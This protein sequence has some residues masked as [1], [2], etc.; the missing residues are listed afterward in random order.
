MAN[1]QIRPEQAKTLATFDD[2]QAAGSALET[3]GYSLEE[4]LHG[5]ISQINRLKHTSTAGNDWFDDLIAPSTFENGAKRGIDLVN[6]D[7]HDFERKRLLCV[8]HNLESIDVPLGQNYVIL[9]A[10]ARLPMNLT[11]AVGAVT[12]LG[13]VVAA[14]T[15]TFGTHSLDVVTG[16]N[17]LNP[18]NI[19]P[20]VDST[21]RDPILSSNRQVY[22]LLQSENA[23]DGHTI[24]A[25]TPNRLQISFVRLDSVGG[26]LEAVPVSDI[27]QVDFTYAA[28]E[29]IG[30]EDFDEQVLLPGAL[31]DTTA[32]GSGGGGTLEERAVATT[33]GLISANT[34]VIGSGGGANLTNV[35]LDYSGVDFA[36]QVK[37]YLNGRLMRNGVNPGS[38]FDV[39]PSAI[40]AEQEAG[41]FY[42]E[43]DIQ[44]GDTIQMFT[45][46]ATPGSGTAAWGGI[47]GTLSD[48]T[49]LQTALD[50][51]VDGPHKHYTFIRGKVG[52]STNGRYYRAN[53][54]GPD[55]YLAYAVNGGAVQGS[56]NA[57]N[58]GTYFHIVPFDG[59][60]TRIVGVLHSPVL[61]ED[62][63]L[64]LWRHAVTDDSTPVLTE[65]GT[66][67]GF[68]ACNGA[69]VTNAANQYKIDVPVSTNNTVARGDAL[70][71]LFYATTAV[72]NSAIVSLMVEISET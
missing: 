50:A 10:A 17:A 8:K 36:T 19:V 24:L 66:A 58:L 40:T 27:E 45:G 34:L 41:A 18:K 60:V 2:Q 47:T 6:Q 32:G 57:P 16:F 62:V 33:T 46:D 44:S 56:P 22:G 71:L 37:I 21:T 25:N 15:G 42:C 72:S 11:A 51:K 1:T 48:Q 35:L 52:G 26:T 67:G 31:F 39:Y 55:I 63:D 68:F 28:V 14:H 23:T 49:D 12:T 7:L 65:I 69:T 54:L 43:F 5:V 53:A 3:P 9:D 29:R 64:E 30:L 38:N 70:E 13:T 59:T 20:V 4:F 61:G